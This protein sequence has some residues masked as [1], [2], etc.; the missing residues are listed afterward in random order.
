MVLMALRWDFS[1]KIVPLVVGTVALI[2]GRTS[3]FNDMCRKPEPAV[4]SLAEQAMREVEQQMAASD[5][6]IHMDLTSDTAHLPTA[7]SSSS[8]R[9]GSSAISSPSWR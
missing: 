1:A 3:L 4:G 7:R 6:K 8:G 5:Q 9:P 2:G